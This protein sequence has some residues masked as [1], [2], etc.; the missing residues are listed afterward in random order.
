M[1]NCLICNK[2]LGMITESHMKKYHQITC[3]NYAKKFNIKKGEL[4]KQHSKKMT[5]EGNP[6]Y[7]IIMPQKLRN[8]I[9][10][11]HKKSGRFKGEGNPMFGKTHTLKVKKF[12]SEHL[13]GAMIGKNNPFYGKKHTEETKERLSRNKKE[14]FKK[15]P[16]KHINNI[17]R[18]RYG[19][20]KNKKGGFISE[21]Q[22][23][24][25]KLIKSQLFKD[26]KLNYPIKTEESLYFADI[27]IPSKKLD[28]KYD[29]RYWHLDE[30]KDDERDVAI[31][32]SGW[33]V[34][35][36]KEGAI[37]GYNEE[38]LIEHVNQLIKENQVL[39][40]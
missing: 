38:D 1:V 37:K 11:I 22:I 40:G 26:A 8:K 35:R 28:I 7:G 13:K 36:V 10:R 23:K 30:L 29:S 15:Y 21:A 32:R 5:G 19:L 24:L 14:L 9:R 4:N 16:E 25:Y 31:I 6:R 17:I 34:V 39:L 2:K 20:Q 33:L 18:K 27:G 12:L 3:K